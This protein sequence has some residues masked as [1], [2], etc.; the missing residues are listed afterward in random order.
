MD[1]ILNPT[2][3]FEYYKEEVTWCGVFTVTLDIDYC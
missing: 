1:R 3:N 2:T